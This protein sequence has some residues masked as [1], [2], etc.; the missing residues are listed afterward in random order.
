MARILL[1]TISS[2]GWTR[3]RH[4]DT[5]VVG[6]VNA[7]K[8]AGNDILLVRCNDF[9]DKT[10]GKLDESVDKSA[11]LK[12]LRDFSPDL[13]LTFN[14][15]FPCEEFITET[16][17]PIV[18]YQADGYHFFA[19]K[20]QIDNHLPRYLF[21][22]LN[23]DQRSNYLLNI[24]NIDERRI[25]PFGYATDFGARDVPQDVAISFLGSI[26]NYTDCL[27]KYFAGLPY[28]QAAENNALK[29][30]FIQELERFQKDP[31]SQFAYRLPIPD[32]GASD[33]TIL[34]LH[35]LTTKIRFEILSGLADLGLSIRGNHASYCRAAMYNWELLRAFDFELCV[36]QDQAETLYNRSKISLNLPNA[37]ALHGFSWRVPDILATNSVLLSPNAPVLASLMDGYAALPMY[38]SAA[39]ARTIAEKLLRDEVWRREL[40]AASRRMVEDKCRFE[41]NFKVMESYLSM[42]LFSDSEGTAADIRRPEMFRKT[43]RQRLCSIVRDLKKLLPYCM[44][45]DMFNNNA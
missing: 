24:K 21:L 10:I 37:Q 41:P 6:F 33:M 44:A 42:P 13:L 27:Y 16:D 18:N 4:H 14:N 2:L 22:S 19:F 23:E 25:C 29:D 12:A 30:A 20:D 36:T 11:L 31:Y 38:S 43:N 39:E 26:P 9:M 34:A 28:S 15:T 40:S 32:I 17:C 7:L 35:T 1:S 3:E 8:R 5:F 45:K